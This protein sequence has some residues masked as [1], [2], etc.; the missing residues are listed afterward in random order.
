MREVTNDDLWAAF[1]GCEMMTC[2]VTK[3]EAMA[4]GAVVVFHDEDGIDPFAARVIREAAR[5][6]LAIRRRRG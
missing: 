1:R 6:A 2:E 5:Q 4:D 3:L